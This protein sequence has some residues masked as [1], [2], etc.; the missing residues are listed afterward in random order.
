MEPGAEYG[1]D[2]EDDD[3]GAC[4]ARAGMR[5]HALFD[6]DEA[7]YAGR[8]KF[9]HGDATFDI[10]YDDGDHKARVPLADLRPLPEQ[11]GRATAAEVAV[12]RKP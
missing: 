2:F 5:V 4:W 11:P 7:W 10:A 1:D 12:A 6:D 9:D 8:I 3:A